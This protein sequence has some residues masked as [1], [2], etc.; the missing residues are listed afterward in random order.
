[1]PSVERIRL[2]DNNVYVVDG[3]DGR[4]LVDAGP[5]YAGAWEALRAAAGEVRSVFVTHGHA[6]HA[7]LGAQWRSAGATVHL[8]E[9]DPCLVGRLFPDEAGWRVLADFV[10]SCGAPPDLAAALVAGLQ[11]RREQAERVSK[12]RGHPPAGRGARHPT[13]LRYEPFDPQPM[14]ERLPNGL[15]ALHLPGH[16]PGTV[17][18]VAEDEGVL[19][20][21]DQLLPDLT[22]TPGIQA[23]P[24]TEPPRRFRS[25]TGFLRGLRLLRGMGLRRCS[26]GHGEPFDDVDAALD[27]TIAAIEERTE[28]VRRALRELGRATPYEL[29]AFLYPRAVERRFWQV[30]PTIQGHLDLLEDRGLVRESG[31]AYCPY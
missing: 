5:D 15:R 24:G 11:R 10:R 12:A 6:D 1:V 31:G 7:G 18:F 8:H 9:L 17:V 13:G 20:S 14:P 2:A 25:L 4:L 27:A 16:T 3:A 29:A 30:L 23:E 19:F 26:P 28:R 21:G 22:P